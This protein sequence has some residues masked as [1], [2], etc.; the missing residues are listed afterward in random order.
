MWVFYFFSDGVESVNLK[1]RV[2]VAEKILVFLYRS[3]VT[4]RR[5]TNFILFSIGNFSELGQNRT[6]DAI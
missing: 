2:G 4:N 3:T 5:V 6:W 1:L